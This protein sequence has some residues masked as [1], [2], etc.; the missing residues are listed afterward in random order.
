M[1]PS[2]NC[3]QTNALTFI[4]I[5]FSAPKNYD[6][7]PFDYI[8]IEYMFVFVRGAQVVHFSVSFFLFSLS[9]FRFTITELRSYSYRHNIHS[10]EIFGD[11]VSFTFHETRLSEIRE[12]VKEKNQRNDTNLPWLRNLNVKRTTK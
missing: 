9:I 10:V 5:N 7:P 1:K 11:M 8:K 12:E 3:A 4:Y 6:I 2:T